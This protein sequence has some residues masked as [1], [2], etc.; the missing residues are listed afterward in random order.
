MSAQWNRETLLAPIMPDRPCGEDLEDG[1]LF[2]ALDAM[3]IFGRATPLDNPGD[4]FER[5]VNWQDVGAHALDGLARSK[6]LRLLTYLAAVSLRTDGLRAFCETLD[7]AWRWLESSWEDVYPRD[8]GDLMLIL[9]RNTLS[10][11]ADPMAIVERLQRTPLVES[12]RY[13]VFSLRDIEIAAGERVPGSQDVVHDRAMIDA[14]FEE[15]PAGT[16]ARLRRRVDEAVAA[17]DAMQERMERAGAED[18]PAFEP[19]RVRLL[20]ISSVLRDQL[21]ARSSVDEPDDDA[22]VQT[23]AFVKPGEVITSREEALHE[24]DRLAE[25]FRRTAPGSP[26][27]LLLERARRLIAVE[28][29]DVL[30]DMPVDRGAG[31][32]IRPE[33]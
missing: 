9:R 18:P 21:A 13:G 7:V 30:A 6:D 24:L 29:V 4:H 5:A 32:A 15:A 3:R 20:R 2:S 28:F 33:G 22:P 19:L 25:Y 26:V 10:C 14:A 12:R 23:S 16:L 8:E 31:D 1:F 17:L 27:P 11:F